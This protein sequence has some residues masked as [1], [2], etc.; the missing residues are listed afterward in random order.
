MKSRGLKIACVLRWPR[1][2]LSLQVAWHVALHEAESK[3]W[4]SV[5]GAAPQCC[6]RCTTCY[7]GVGGPTCAAGNYMPLPMSRGG[8]CICRPGGTV[9]A[10]NERQ[11]AP[12]RVQKGNP[13]VIMRLVGC[14]RWTGMRAC[15]YKHVAWQVFLQ[16]AV[17]RK[18]A[19][20]S[21]LQNMWAVWLQPSAVACYGAAQGATRWSLPGLAYIVLFVVAEG[22]VCHCK[23]RPHGAFHVA[24]R[25]GPSRSYHA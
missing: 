5:P 14:A 24:N 19:L 18:L 17:V 12:Q 1:G 2:R 21:V 22:Q 25:R 7:A 11:A 4:A 6:L 20:A 23:S 3:A 16:H 13:A 9:V 15:M 8:L 10:R